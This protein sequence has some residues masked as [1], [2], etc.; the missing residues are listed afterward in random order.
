MIALEARSRGFNVQ[1]AGGINLARDP[2]NGRNFEYLSEDPLLSAVFAAESIN[3]IQGEGVISTIKHYS[4]NCN[5]TNRHWLDAIIDPSAHRESDLLAFEIAIERSQPGSVMTGY[6]KIN[7]DYA[8]GNRVLLEDV[9]KGA[10]NYPGWV[11]SDWGATPSWEFALKGLDQESGLQIDQFYWNV[12]SFVEPLREAYTEGKLS[13]ERLSEM[14]CRILRS[15]FAVGIDAWGSAPVLVDMAKHNEIALEMARQGIVL[16]KNDGVLPL[17]A[18]TTAR[19]AVIGGHAHIGVPIGTGSSAVVPPG[20][21]AA[22][23]AISGPGIM[24]LARNSISFRHHL[25][26]N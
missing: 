23:I 20:G 24:G 19:I 18:D 16:L 1:L 10:W 5:E 2:R 22:E 12:Q 11:M 15:M 14:V 3:G 4:L 21:Y 8:G 9:L 7:G 25:S 13:K 26:K 6:N 17:A